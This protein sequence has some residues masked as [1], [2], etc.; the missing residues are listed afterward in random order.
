[1][2]SV[3]SPPCAGA[4]SMPASSS[5]RSIERKPC[6]TA[7]A[8]AARHCHGSIPGS[9]ASAS[10]AISSGSTA[11]AV[12]RYHPNDNTSATG[13]KPTFVPES[14]QRSCGVR[15]AVRCSVQHWGECSGSHRWSSCTRSGPPPAGRASPSIRRSSRSDLPSQPP[16]SATR[17]LISARHRAVQRLDPTSN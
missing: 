16:E 8:I 1:M 10:R 11:W 4:S 13:S 7:S 3:F 2:S 12:I 6:C 17:K 14:T 15:A 9:T 5:A